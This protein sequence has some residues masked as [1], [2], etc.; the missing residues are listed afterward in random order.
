MIDVNVE[1]ENERNLITTTT[2][3]IFGLDSCWFMLTGSGLNE[4]EQTEAQDKQ[5]E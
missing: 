3:M 4:T 2:G 5:I 1:E